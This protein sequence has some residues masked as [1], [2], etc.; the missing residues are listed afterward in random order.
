MELS[1]APIAL[2]LQF[3]GFRF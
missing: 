2:S 3:R 1:L